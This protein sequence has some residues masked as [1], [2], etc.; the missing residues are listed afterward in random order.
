MRS[1][2]TEAYAI[3]VTSDGHAFITGVTDTKT[4]PTTQH[5]YQRDAPAGGGHPFVS[6][7][8]PNGKSF[9]FSTY[10]GSTGS[11]KCDSN[12]PG[13]DWGTGIAVNGNG[14][15]YV[16]G[17]TCS[18]KFVTWRAMFIPIQWLNL[19][20]YI[21]EQIDFPAAFV[22]QL[23]NEGHQPFFSTYLG[24]NGFTQSN[25]IALD[26][27][28][29]PPGIYVTGSTSAKSFPTT[30]NA[31]QTHRGGRSSAF[32][33]KFSTDGQKIV[34]STFLGGDNGDEGRGIAVDFERHAY[35]VGNYTSFNFPIT[36][37]LTPHA[38]PVPGIF[39]AK[40]AQDGGS[41]CV[42][43]DS[44]GGLGSQSGNSIAV[45]DHAAYVTGTTDARDFPVK[46]AFQAVAPG[47]RDAFVSKISEDGKSFSYS[48]FLGGNQNDEGNGI[49]V[50][51]GGDAYVTGRTTSPN[52]PTHNP[53]QPTLSGTE[54]A[55][56]TRL[57]LSSP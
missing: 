13:V 22:F 20:T 18:A 33:T 57:Q 15:P 54:S 23:D 24:G 43:C 2:S 36:H 47:A 49:A 52:F 51:P 29:L 44:L 55:F 39:I 4:F 38:E 19:T 9:V 26:P 53:F 40:L 25:A 17:I 41:P 5:A 14:E 30:K 35:V 7:I 8:T 46:N 1:G 48:T 16:T 28:L 11:H 42:Y 37:R 12:D 32:I 3:A 56:V 6:E 10:F 50:G 31:F 21:G 27:N 34:Y 45:F